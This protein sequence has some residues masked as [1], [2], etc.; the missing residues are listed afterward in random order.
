MDTEE[1]QRKQERLQ[2]RRE[3]ELLHGC[4][5]PPVSRLVSLRQAAARLALSPGPSPRGVGP[6]D[7]ATARSAC[8]CD[9]HKLCSPRYLLYTLPG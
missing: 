3:R 2:R 6:G 5:P 4:C 8:K 1:N 7:K 9:G